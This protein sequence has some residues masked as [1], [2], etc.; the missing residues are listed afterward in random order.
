MQGPPDRVSHV[1]LPGEEGADLRRSQRRPG[2]PA[3]GVSGGQAE[4]DS[5]AHDLRALQAD[6]EH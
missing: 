5:Q 1:L 3:D 4:E 6:G 2:P